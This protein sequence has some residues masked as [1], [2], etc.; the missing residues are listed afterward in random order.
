M[1]AAAWLVVGVGCKEAPRS[2]PGATPGVAQRHDDG[3]S[4][5]N[6]EGVKLIDVRTPGEFAGGHLPGAINAPVTDLDGVAAAVGAPDAPAV[7]Y[8]AS[9]ARSGHAV[10]ALQARGYTRVVNGGG[11]RAA[12]ARLGVSLVR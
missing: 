9:G 5:W 6:A 11:A 10:K 8:C 3:A 1:A 4:V 12:A 2:A 7:I